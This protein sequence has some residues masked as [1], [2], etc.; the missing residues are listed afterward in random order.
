MRVQ[1]DLKNAK[2]DMKS[3]QFDIRIV[4]I[5]VISWWNM[6]V[7]CLWTKVRDG[8]WFVYPYFTKFM[9]ILE[10]NNFRLLFRYRQN[11]VT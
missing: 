5:S 7:F 9:A 10:M 3:V 8:H 1:F 11:R 4:Y 2:L 6:N